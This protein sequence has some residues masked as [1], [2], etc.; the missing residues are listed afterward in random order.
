MTLPAAT[1]VT[2][3]AAPPRTDMGGLRERLE[4]GLRSPTIRAELPSYRM[5]RARGEKVRA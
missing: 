1:R 3:L 5:R 2:T 4:I